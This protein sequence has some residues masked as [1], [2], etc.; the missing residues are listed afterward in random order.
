[1]MRQ[2]SS[3]WSNPGSSKS[4]K[5]SPCDYFFEGTFKGWIFWRTSAG[6]L[7]RRAGFLPYFTADDGL[8]ISVRSSLGS[9]SLTLCRS[10]TLALS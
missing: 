5:I 9:F 6:S 10:I 8:G 3:T 7:V 4:T 1:M 2:G